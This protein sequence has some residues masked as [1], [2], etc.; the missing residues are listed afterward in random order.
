[1]VIRGTRS[2]GTFDN[3]NDYLQFT[4]SGDTQPGRVIREIDSMTSFTRYLPVKTV[5]GDKDGDRM[6]DHGVFEEPYIYDTASNRMAPDGIRLDKTYRTYGR[7]DFMAMR[8]G[9]SVI[10]KYEARLHVNE[11]KTWRVQKL[12]RR[13]RDTALDIE[14]DLLYDSVANDTKNCSGI[15]TRFTAITDMRGI[16]KSG[17]NQGKLS[18]YITIDA[19]GTGEDLASI[20]IM[21]PDAEYGITRLVPASGTDYTDFV[22]IQMGHTDLGEP[23]HRKF[24]TLDGQSGNLEYTIDQFDVVYGVGLLSRGACIR[25]A[26]IDWSDS[27]ETNMIKVRD[28]YRRAVAAIDIKLRKKP[29]LAVMNPEVRICLAD[30]LD[31]EILKNQITVAG[32]NNIPESEDVLLPGM[33]I[34][35]CDFMTTAED[36]VV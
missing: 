21:V 30:F 29:K 10:Y 3:M 13:V 5:S 8:G 22:K 4:D 18:R 25:I 12:L 20:L 31:R 19:G 7:S 15:M 28:A 33:N 27:S 9:E 23:W 16:I 34:V 6:V 2:R 1:M 32:V 26:N 36:Q 11:I 35:E 17:T 24:V 14:H